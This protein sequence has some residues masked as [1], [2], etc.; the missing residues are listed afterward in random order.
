MDKMQIIEKRNFDL[1]YD[2]K[3]YL[4]RLSEIWD[5]IR[6][7][8]GFVDEIINGCITPLGDKAKEK[9]DVNKINEWEETLEKISD[10]VYDSGHGW[11]KKLRALSLWRQLTGEE[12]V[13]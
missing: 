11:C 2:E 10:E 3:L 9:Y 12:T 13:E 5:S 6:D 1:F 8:I 4:A 7:A